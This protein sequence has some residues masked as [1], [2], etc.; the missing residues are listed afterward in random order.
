MNAMSSNRRPRLTGMAADQVKVLRTLEGRRVGLAIRGGRR[1]DDCQLV[2]AGRGRVQT[3][4]VFAAGA[5]TFVSLDD[6]VD[7]WEAA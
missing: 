2:S 1:I 3:V 7:V 6:V 4:W 5:D